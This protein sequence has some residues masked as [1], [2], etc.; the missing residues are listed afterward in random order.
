MFPCKLCYLVRVTGTTDLKQRFLNT[1]MY[2]ENKWLTEKE[3][4][5]SDAFE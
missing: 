5:I 3:N 2:S 4:K 1:E